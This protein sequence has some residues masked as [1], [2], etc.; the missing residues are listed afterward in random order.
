MNIGAIV[1][2]AVGGVFGLALVVLLGILAF[3]RRDSNRVAAQYPGPAALVEPTP[4]LG[5]HLSGSTMATS[6]PLMSSMNAHTIN[7]PMQPG[8]TGAGYPYGYKGDPEV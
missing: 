1:G 4:T 7:E 2:G 3:R 8:G 6:G 5:Y